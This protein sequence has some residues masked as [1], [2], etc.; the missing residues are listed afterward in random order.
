MGQLQASPCTHPLDQG[1]GT[2]TQ[3]HSTALDAP[4]LQRVTAWHPRALPANALCP[5]PPAFPICPRSTAS[6]VT[7]RSTIRRLREQVEA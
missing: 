1:V 6:S 3:G 5:R 7:V 4:S 2:N